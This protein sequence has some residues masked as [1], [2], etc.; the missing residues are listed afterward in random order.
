MTQV[1]NLRNWKN[2]RLESCEWKNIHREDE[3]FSLGHDEFEV[4]ITH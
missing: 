4:S 3:E 2:N 1:F